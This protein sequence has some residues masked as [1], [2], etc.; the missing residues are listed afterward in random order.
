VLGTSGKPFDRLSAQ[1]A[2]LTGA[3]RHTRAHPHRFGCH[4]DRNLPPRQRMHYEDRQTTCCTCNISSCTSLR[5]TTYFTKQSP[6]ETKHGACQIS[7]GVIHYEGSQPDT[8]DCH[9]QAAS[10]DCALAAAAPLQSTNP[11]AE[12]GEHA[13]EAA[14]QHNT[15]QPRHGSPNR[16]WKRPVLG[17]CHAEKWWQR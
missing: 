5:H 13:E 1:P 11:L 17:I 4:P 9:I 12:A 3:G 7:Y 16:T 10:C 14:T 2:P 8:S 6:A 15:T